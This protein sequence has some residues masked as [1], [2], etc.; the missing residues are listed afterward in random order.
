MIASIALLSHAIRVVKKPGN[1]QR[2]KNSK[3]GAKAARKAGKEIRIIAGRLLRDIAGKLPLERLGTHLP[4]LKLYQWV[5]SQKR[6]DTNK[7]TY[8][9]INALNLK[10][11]F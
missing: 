7:I 3:Q 1:Q 6:G 4:A 9:N 11:T 10:P 5:L 2:F 8:W